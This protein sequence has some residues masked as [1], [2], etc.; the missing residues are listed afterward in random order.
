[1]LRRV[2]GPKKNEIIGGWKNLLNEELHYLCSSPNAMRMVKTRR[3]WARYVAD[4]G[5]MPT[6]FWWENQKEREHQEDLDVGGRIIIKWTLE[7]LDGVI[8]LQDM[9]PAQALLNT[10]MNLRVP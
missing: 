9:G 7:K 6:R 1:V 5:E 2:F 3:R 10:A 8:G 4:I